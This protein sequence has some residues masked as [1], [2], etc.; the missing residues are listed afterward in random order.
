LRN[1]GFA[2]LTGAPFRGDLLERNYTLM[3][4]VFSLGPRVL[5][6]ACAHPEIG[7][8]RGYMPTRTEVG[9]R[10]GGEP[11]DKEV[12][13]F[14]SYRN[15]GVPSVPGY[16]EAAEEYYAACQDI[17]YTL[18]HVLSAYLDPEGRER[19]YMLGLFRAPDGSRID[20][21]HM[22]HIRYPGS[23]ARMACE[24][25]D[26]NMISLLPAATRSGLQV[27][28]NEGAWLPVDA[29]PGDLVVNAGDMLNMISGGRIRS[30]LHR[31]ENTAPDASI[32]RYSMPF[33]YHPDHTQELRILASCT[34]EPV[35]RRMF[36][37][38]SITGYHLL[39][40]LLSTYR[41]IPAD[42]NVEEWIASM[43]A[44]K[45]GH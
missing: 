12:M 41:V 14:G 5:L 31:V 4:E 3:R 40:E 23:A 37:Y 32:Y 24:H 45:S 2:V 22:R 8:Q 20:D 26:S 25:T 18:M 17:G 33:F 34:G 16:L 28:N 9:I 15:V 29:E 27:M 13:A 1:T 19:E 30:T 21:S 10:C 7:Y 36:P 6:R 42:V 43:E 35:E 11:D 44:L 38:H 39:Y